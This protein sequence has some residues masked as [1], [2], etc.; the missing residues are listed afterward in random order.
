[1]NIAVKPNVR[2]IL[3]LSVL[4]LTPLSVAVGQTTG[5][6]KSK[7]T[8]KDETAIKIV[9][10]DLIG[11][12]NRHEVKAFSMLFADNADFI[13]IVG[14]IT[15]GRAEIEKLHARL[16]GTIFKE[17][18]VEPT[19]LRIRFLKSD[20]AAVDSTWGVTGY[21][22]PSDNKHSLKKAVMIVSFIMIKNKG[23]WSI[24]VMHKLI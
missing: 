4:V 13:D 16:F 22:D 1:M 11:E 2:H 10:T 3:I 17:S 14:P 12:W 8:A 24:A 5:K 7:G 21:I 15:E 23:R 19:G 18:H 20:V 6:V 9:I